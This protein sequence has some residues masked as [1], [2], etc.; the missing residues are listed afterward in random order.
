MVYF[1]CVGSNFS[2]FYLF[3][4]FKTLLEEKKGGGGGRKGEK[5]KME[6]H[7]NQTSQPITHTGY[8]TDTNAPVRLRW[9]E[10]LVLTERKKEEKWKRTAVGRVQLRN[11]VVFSKKIKPFFSNLIPGLH[12]F[13]HHLFTPSSRPPSEPTSFLPAITW[14][15]ARPTQP[16]HRT[17]VGWKRD[18][19]APERPSTTLPAIKHLYL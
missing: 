18:R 8:K 16:Q 12:S 13:T 3:I 9:S 5:K 11:P 1:G 10:V 6:I 17:P 2:F 14:N 7:W 4:L 15:G 19:S